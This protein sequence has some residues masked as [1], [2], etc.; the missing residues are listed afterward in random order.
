MSNSPRTNSE[1]WRDYDVTTIDDG[2]KQFVSGDAWMFTVRGCKYTTITGAGAEVG[3]V[4]DV[5]SETTLGEL[6]ADDRVSDIDLL[7]PLSDVL[8]AFKGDAD[9]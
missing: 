6:A 1:T 2:Y 8:S 4:V 3:P 7:V 9:E 5:Q